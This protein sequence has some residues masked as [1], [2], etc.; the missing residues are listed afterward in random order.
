M[1]IKLNEEIL[2]SFQDLANTDCGIEILIRRRVEQERSL[3]DTLKK[4]YENHN[5]TSAKIDHVMCELVLPF[6]D[7]KQS[8]A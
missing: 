1:K 7:E 8:L 3:W 2:T 6:E 5:F 4:K